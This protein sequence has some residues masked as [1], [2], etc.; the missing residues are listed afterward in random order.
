MFIIDPTTRMTW[1]QPCSAEPLYKYQMLGVLMSIAVYNSITLPITFPIAFY[2]KLLDLKVK[3][4]DHIQDGWPDLAKGLQQLLDWDDG[5]VSEVFM[6]TYDFSFEL[7]GEV[8]NVNMEKRLADAPWQPL[9]SRRTAALSE[10]STSTS[11]PVVPLSDEEGR[12]V[13]N[14]TRSQF[15]KDYVSWLTDKSIQPQ[16]SA[17]ASGFCTCLDKSALGIFTPETL[18]DVIEGSQDFAAADLKTVTKYEDG[19]TEDSKIVQ[20]FWEIVS[21]YDQTWR[22]KLLEFVTASDRIPVLGMSSVVFVIQRNGAFSEEDRGSERLPTSMTCF[23]RL[24]LPEY[25]S[26][27]LLEEKLGRALEN[28]QGFGVA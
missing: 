1:F 15:V 18:K 13:T 23:G 14:A 11:S 24:L 10:S 16:F 5:D 25:G 2:R 17:F 28:S 8:V 27:A 19:Y 6:R 7:F 20:W 4:L 22:S 21:T 12:V 3:H 26:K 9:R